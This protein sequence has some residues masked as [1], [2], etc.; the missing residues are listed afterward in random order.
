MTLYNVHSACYEHVN[1][2]WNFLLENLKMYGENT[3]DDLK[4][5][6]A[7]SPKGRFQKICKDAPY[8]L[9]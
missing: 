9:S 2:S 7:A 1:R 3:S 4:L 8:G 6:L 5:H